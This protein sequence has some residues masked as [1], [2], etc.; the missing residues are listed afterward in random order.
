MMGVTLS[1]GGSFRWL[2]DTLCG[3][4]VRIARE[5]GKDPYELMVEEGEKVKPGSEGLI[6]LPYLMGERTPYPDPDARGVFMGL[7]LRHTKAH[8]IRAVME[9]VTFSLKDCL[10][11]IRELGVA[12]DEVRASGG[13]SRSR[14]WRQIQA[15]IFNAEVVCIN[16]DEGPAFGAALLAGV[17]TGVFSSVEE[18]CKETIKITGR[19]EP[20]DESVEIYKDYYRIY[21]SLYPL[22]RDSFRDISLR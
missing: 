13:G 6:F 2:R 18:A 1:A 11:I 8:M 20:L 12:V 15:N 16:V 19:I 3:E 5:R 10:E 22:L 17:G 14:L 4:E 7:T 9:G 21:R